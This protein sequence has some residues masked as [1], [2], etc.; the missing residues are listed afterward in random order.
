MRLVLDRIRAAQR[1]IDPV[2]LRT[3]LFEAPPLSALL[4]CT[5]LLKVETVNPVRSF[6]GRGAETITAALLAGGRHRSA[7]CASAGNLGLALAYSGARRGLPVTVFA[8]ETANPLKVER[9]RSAGATMH[10]Q[11]P[12]I[13]V[14]RGLA[15]AHAAATGSYLVEDSLDIGICEGAATIGFELLD[16]D[17]QPDV[18][19]LALGGGALASGVGYV[20]HELSP[21]TE[22]IAV[23]PA[24]APAMALSWRAKTVVN[25]DSIDTIADG[26]A[27]RYPIPQVLEDLLTVVDDTLLVG[28]ASIRVGMRHLFDGAGLAVEPSAALGIAAILEDRARFAGRTVATVICGSNV[29]ADDFR[30]WALDATLH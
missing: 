6:K 24:G 22:V 11:G 26:V 9:M 25:T 18:V 30:R 29:R 1:V 20:L 8:A 16:A 4:G 23:Q 15:R 21:G 27:G 12:D 7:V 19:L 5:V 2:F 14:P 28:E 10:L 17:P 13:E 3:P